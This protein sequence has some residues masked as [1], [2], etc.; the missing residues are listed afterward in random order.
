MHAFLRASCSLGLR[1]RERHCL[2]VRL[3]AKQELVSCQLLAL[4]SW[5]CLL[6]SVQVACATSSNKQQRWV[7][8]LFLSTKSTRLVASAAQVLAVVTMNAS[9]HSTKCSPRWTA[10]KPQ[11]ALSCWLLPTALTSWMPHCCDQVDLI[12]RSSCRY[13]NQMNAWPFSKC[14]QSASAW[15]KMSIWTRWPKQLLA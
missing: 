15:V 10:S 12:V 11:K 7:E 3:Q 8:Q 5:R 14:T 4:T 13:Q 6:A 2:L 9:R 1:A